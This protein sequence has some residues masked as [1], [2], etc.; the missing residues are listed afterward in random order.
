MDYIN[1]LKELDKKRDNI[2]KE[3]TINGYI[4][5]DDKL[6]KRTKL[7]VVEFYC[8]SES[9]YESYGEFKFSRKFFYISD[10]F[11]NKMKEIDKSS[12][13][14]EK[15][16]YEILNELRILDGFNVI[17]EHLDMFYDGIEKDDIID[18][19]NCEDMDEYYGCSKSYNRDYCMELSFKKE[20]GSGQGYF[21]IYKINYDEL[22]KYNEFDIEFEKVLNC[23]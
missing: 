23:N 8:R 6:I 17:E 21:S 4:Y 2:I 14:K 12:D 18:I 7:P 16:L 22:N 11:F 3:A 10:D 20:D 9:L 5:K 1:K 15:V 13:N 19:I